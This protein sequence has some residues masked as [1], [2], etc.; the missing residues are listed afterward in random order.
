MAPAAAIM[1]PVARRDSASWIATLAVGT[2][3]FLFYL[4]HLAPDMQWGDSARLAR[5]AYTGD[6]DFVTGGGHGLTSALGWLFG[7]L[8]FPH[9]WTQNLLS[10]VLSASALAVFMRILAALGVPGWPSVFAGTALGISHTFWFVSELHESYALLS[11]TFAMLL[12][13][14][15]ALL[16]RPTAARM[17]AW[18]ACVSAG[19]LN[20]HL[21]FLLGG[22]GWIAFLFLLNARL[23]AAWAASCWGI[24][25]LSAGLLTALLG[26]T[27][28]PARFV[29]TFRYHVGTYFGAGGYAKALGQYAA[30]LAFQFAGPALLLGLR[31]IP[32]LARTD[33][34]FGTVLLVLFAADVLFA[35]SYGLG[36]RMYLFLPSHMI[37][38]LLAGYGGE[39]F[40]AR[41]PRPS[42]AGG[43]LLTG[44]VGIPLVLYAATPRLLDAQGEAFLTRRVLPHLDANRYYLW[45]GKRG[46]EGPAR[47]VAELR[48]AAGPGGMV[49]ADYKVLSL[50]KYDFALSG[51]GGIGLFQTDDLAGLPEE[52]A[53]ARLEATLDRALA[54]G[55]R[56]VLADPGSLQI[57][58]SGGV[59]DLFPWLSATYV[60]APFENCFLVREKPGESTPFERRDR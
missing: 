21:F 24:W 8:P 10:A 14:S 31:G 22:A 39:A 29:E 36:R 42:L 53:E 52:T 17:A 26:W 12:R 32:S 48:A 28:G 27:D 18:A 9:P 41:L 44:A 11:L 59:V 25:L 19:I 55:R 33:R 46:E 2:A 57:A 45:P 16:A 51:D 23:R 54:A 34:R 47:F 49:V 30:I 56:V 1:R 3:F 4:Y 5:V 7:K 43:T 6:A 60:V 35:S 37:F 58:A 38:A 50:L 13:L 20:H 40:L 15:V